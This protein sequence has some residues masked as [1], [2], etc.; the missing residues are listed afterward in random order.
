MTSP[1]SLSPIAWLERLAPRIADPDRQLTIDKF[2]RYYSGD[3]DLP[4]G[5]SQM[6][7]AFRSFQAKARTNLCGICVRSVADRMEVIGYRERDRT[8]NERLWALWTAS[9]MV[10][11]QSTIWRKALSLGSAYVVVG[12]DPRRRDAPRFT[13][14]GPDRIA[15]EH[16]PGDPLVRLA[17]ARVWHDALAR[18]WHATIYLPGWR[19]YF[20]TVAE[21]VSPWAT[22]TDRSQGSSLRLNATKWQTRLPS[23]RSTPDIPVIPFYNGEE[24]DEPLAEFAGEGIDVQDRIN[25]TVLSRLTTERYQAYRQRG[26]VNFEPAEDPITGLPIPPFRPGSDQ[27]WTVPPAAPGDPEPK[28]VDLPPSDTANI[29]RAVESDI[30]SFA[31]VTITPVY[32][33]PGGDLI[34]VAADALSALDTGHNAK[35]RQKSGLWTGPLSQMWQLAAD[36]AGL[37]VTIEPEAIAWARPESAHPAAVADY[38]SKMVAAGVPL[39][40]VL[41]EIGWGPERIEQVRTEVAQAQ[42]QAS[43][44]AARTAAAGQ[45]AGRVNGQATTTGGSP[46]GS[47]QPRGG[48]PAAGPAGSRVP[49]RRPANA[50]AA[51]GGR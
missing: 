28:F 49:G 5:P 38:V 50:G 26:L 10:A 34:N 11:R 13:I 46:N 23:E 51:P 31:M 2:R 27:I 8:A 40:I 6:S 17:A 7:D 35:V 18:R 42:I 22:D 39:T 25:L 20:Q 41:E 14:E 48:G 19:H 33:L 32:Y 3:H 24:G 16:D 44:L 9:G 29:L 12:P 1:V 47:Q 43:V 21:H 4:A 15:V 30:R 37:G 45:P 36:V